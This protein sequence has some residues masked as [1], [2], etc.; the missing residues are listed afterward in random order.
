MVFSVF[1]RQLKKMFHYIC[2][3]HCYVG[4]ASLSQTNPSDQRLSN[5]AELSIAQSTPCQQDG[6]LGKQEIWTASGLLDVHSCSVRSV[7]RSLYVGYE[8]LLIFL[9]TLIQGQDGIILFIMLLRLFNLLK[10]VRG[11]VALIGSE[12]GIVKYQTIGAGE[13]AQQ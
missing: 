8:A 1:I 3:L 13:M 6:H 10:W 4:Q 12:K 11:P 5:W 2:S 7:L 9:H